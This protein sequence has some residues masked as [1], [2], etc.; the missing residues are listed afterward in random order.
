MIENING[1]LELAIFMVVELALVIPHQL[2][3]IIQ[4]PAII[5][6]LLESVNLF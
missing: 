4:S 5:E 2:S 3:L 6:C 1:I